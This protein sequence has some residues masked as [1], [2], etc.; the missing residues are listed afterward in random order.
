M[1]YFDAPS[2]P[3]KVRPV[4]QDP[5]MARRQPLDVT[6]QK[7][8]QEPGT[9]KLKPADFAL[10]YQNARPSFLVNVFL[11]PGPG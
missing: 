1:E 3:C 2:V 10:S 8:C 7:D 4:A 5:D 6:A 11:A 9:Q